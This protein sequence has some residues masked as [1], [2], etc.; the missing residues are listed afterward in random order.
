[1]DCPG[2]LLQ[3]IPGFPLSDLANF[4]P[5]DMWQGICD[6]AIQIVTLIR[7]RDIRNEDVQSWNV[8]VRKDQSTG[9]F[10][11]VMIDFS[12]CV[13]RKEGQSDHDWER[14]QAEQDEE[15]AIGCVMQARLKG[16]F[17]FKRSAESKRLT[18]KYMRDMRYMGE[19]SE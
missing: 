6:E 2:I 11:P 10:K 18:H 12:R 7:S 17:E 19:M 1:M 5:R 4:A 15:G 3:I 9:R 8:I 16:G 13:F 14:R